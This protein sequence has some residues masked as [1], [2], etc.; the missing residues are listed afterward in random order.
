MTRPDLHIR[1]NTAQEKNCSDCG[2][3]GTDYGVRGNLLPDEPKRSPDEW[4]E[5]C[6]FCYHRREERSRREP[7]LPLGTKP[8]GVPK[9][10]FNKAIRVKTESGSIYEFGA[11]SEDGIRTISSTTRKINYTKCKIFLAI[12]DKSMWLRVVDDPEKDSS[13]LVQTTPVV[14]MEALS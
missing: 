8:P 7:P 10:F 2:E 11:P 4:I 13:H 5:L 9:E 12:P 6:A 14:S 1:A 3:K